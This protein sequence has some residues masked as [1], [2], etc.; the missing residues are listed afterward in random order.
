VKALLL[1]LTLLGTLA[2]APVF[3]DQPTES[4]SLDESLEAIKGEIEDHDW[5]GLLEW[6]DSEH[7]TT[8]LG[9]GMSHAQYVAELLNLNWENNSINADSKTPIAE[10]D[11]NRIKKVFWRTTKSEG[12]GWTTVSGTVRLKGFKTLLIEVSMIKTSA[13][14]RIT[15]AVG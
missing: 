6:A 5:L 4:L 12:N 2:A 1:T 13:G 15:G 9:M 7:R 14:W 8:Q 10:S 11:L 3:A